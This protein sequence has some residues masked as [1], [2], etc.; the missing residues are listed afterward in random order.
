MKLLRVGPVGA[1]KPALLSDDGTVIDIS[2]LVPEIDSAWL[3]DGGIEALR[4]ALADGG[5]SLPSIDMSATRTGAPMARPGNIIAIGLNYED[6][7][8]EAGMDIPGEPIIFTKAPSSYCGPNDTV[9]IPRASEK[10]DWEV[11]LGIVIGKRAQYLGSEAEALEHVAGYTIVN[12]V[13]ERD[14][15]L[16]RG[17]T[18]IK[19]KSAETFCPTGPWLVTRDEVPDPGNLDMRLA[20]NGTVRQDGNTRTMIFDVAHVV[21][22]CSQFMVL[23]AGDL[24]ATGTPPGVGMG[25]KPPLYLQSGDVMELEIVSL[26]QQRQGVAQA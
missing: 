6:H 13:S 26:G 2:S 15:Q 11:E 7:A 1:E 5:D 21:W 25:L 3:E 8:R 24:I 4:V 14:F 19:G 17:P 23:E 22:Y 18:W 10:T 12:D 16:N 20:V 9:L